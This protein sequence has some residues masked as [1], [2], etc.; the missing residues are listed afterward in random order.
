MLNAVA[1]RIMI[2]QTMLTVN[3]VNNT[4]PSYA[5]DAKYNQ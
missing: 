2:L 5:S 1:N 3:H 4:N